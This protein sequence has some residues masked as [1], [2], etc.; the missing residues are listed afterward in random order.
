MIEAENYTGI[1]KS[2]EL[3]IHKADE[4]HYLACPED[5]ASNVIIIGFECQA[6]ELDDFSQKPFEL[7]AE[8]RKLLTE[9]IREGRSVFLPPCLQRIVNDR[10]ILIRECK[11]NI[12]QI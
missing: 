8:C 5:D 1:L 11:V 12:G 3:I 9:V 7:S 4:T 2:G 6:E 10:K